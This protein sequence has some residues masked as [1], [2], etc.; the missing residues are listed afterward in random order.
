[1]RIRLC[2]SF[3]FV[4]I[5]MSVLVGGTV[6][7]QTPASEVACELTPLTLPLFDATPLAT[8]AAEVSP[9]PVGSFSEDQATE[10]L[11]QYV[12]CINTGD[13]TLVWAMFTPRW[14]AREFADPEVHYLPAFE[15]MLDNGANPQPLQDPIALDAIRSITVRPDGM[16]DV[17][18]TFSSDGESWTD[19]LTLALIDGE[20]LI[21]DVHPVDG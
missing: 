7:A 12:A 11:E 2:S 1:M 20:W 9:T 21:D 6:S 15:Q 4:F 19:R 18:A 5:V 10:V 16:V 3:V 14:F 8:V 17:T 13:L